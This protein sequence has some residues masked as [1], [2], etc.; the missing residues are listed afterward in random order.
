MEFTQKPAKAQLDRVLD[1]C[2]DVS[3]DKLD[4]YF[5][6]AERTCTDLLPNSTRQIERGLRAYAAEATKEGCHSLRVVCEPTGG[7]QNKLLRTARRLGFLTTYVSGEA[8]AKFRVVETNDNGK[9]DLKDPRTINTLARVDKGVLPHRVLDEEYSLLRT[10]GLHYEEADGA[11]VQARCRIHH[12]LLEL[13][14]DYSFKNSFLYET[15]GRALMQLYHANPYRIVQAGEQ[16]FYLAMRRQVPRIRHKTLERLWQDAESSVLHQQSDEHLALLE[17][18]VDGLWQDF[19]RQEQRKAEIEDRMVELLDRLRAKDPKV[20]APTPGVISAKNLA[21][22]LGETGPLSDF[23]CWRQLMRYAGLNICMRQS[24]RY[25]GQFRISK[26]GRPL[27]RKILGQIVFPL[28]TRRALYGD[29]F[30]EKR[31]TMPG[32]KAMTTVMRMFLRKL[33]GWHKAGTDFDAERHF[34]CQGD[35]A[36]RQAA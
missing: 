16:A 23:A 8:V 19:L 15:S 17:L 5:E 6:L 1:I 22:L 20:P 32:K 31:Q 27:L 4:V 30:H 2:V 10:C 11:L 36:Q 29:Y 18:H 9:T 25:E 13:F 7:Y 3:K 26:K 34:I 14:P 33:H 35:W 24:G 21:R 12:G 28:V